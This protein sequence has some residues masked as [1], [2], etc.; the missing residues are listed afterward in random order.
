VLGK[1]ES[2]AG[3]VFGKSCGEAAERLAYAGGTA[4]RA[5]VLL[6]GGGPVSQA[7]GGML[8]NL[9][10]RAGIAAGIFYGASKFGIC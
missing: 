7:V 1:V 4:A 5:G 10:A 6:Q 9:G 8:V 3:G 2:S